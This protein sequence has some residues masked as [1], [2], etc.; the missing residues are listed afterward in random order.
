MT[1]DR[2]SGL[3]QSQVSNTAI[4]RL[5]DG[6]LGQLH[7]DRSYRIST[8]LLE[9]ETTGLTWASVQRPLIELGR[10]QSHML[11]ENDPA[12]IAAINEQTLARGRK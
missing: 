6:Q 7:S 5:D 12:Q 11:L 1:E 3:Q 8:S 9:V 10:L 2:S 4:A